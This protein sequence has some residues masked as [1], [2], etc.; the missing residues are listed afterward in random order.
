VATKKGMGLDTVRELA[1]ALPDVE[2]STSYG[3]PG[4]KVRGKLLTCQPINRSA[5]A[6][7]L[8]VR[9]DFDLRAELLAAEPDVYYVTPHYEKY[10][11]VLVRLAK[12][13]RPALAKLL[14]TAWAFVSAKA[15]ARRGTATKRKRPTARKR[16]TR[17]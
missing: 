16:V 11:A 13:R 1:M 10:P 6:D 4:F 15:P 8:M 5:E 9:I 14:G 12:I 2:E 7:S 3:A 17:R